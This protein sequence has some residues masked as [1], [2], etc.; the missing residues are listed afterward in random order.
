MTVSVMQI[1][2]LGIQHV[3]NINLIDKIG[4]IIDTDTQSFGDFRQKNSWLMKQSYE[5]LS[6]YLDFAFEITDE[7]EV[8]VRLR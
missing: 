1:S 3:K 6:K 8:S 2:I 7:L 4:Q 5:E